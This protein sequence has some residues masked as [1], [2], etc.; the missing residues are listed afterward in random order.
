MTVIYHKNPE[1]NRS[2]QK[3]R[4]MRPNYYYYHYYYY[5]Y[6]YYHYSYY[7]YRYFYE[8]PCFAVCV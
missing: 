1:L 2:P 5:H 6:Y 4:N 3:K 7:H 8:Q